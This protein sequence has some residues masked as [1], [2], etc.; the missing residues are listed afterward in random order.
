[1]HEAMAVLILSKAENRK[2]TKFNCKNIFF[3]TSWPFFL[4]SRR[5]FFD[6]NPNF[7]N[8]T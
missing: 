6:K 8:P 1:M 7:S 5:Q 4:I 2:D 3:V